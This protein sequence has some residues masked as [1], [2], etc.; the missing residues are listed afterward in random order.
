MF[1]KVVLYCEYCDRHKINIE[2][3][4]T[5]SVAE[6][7]KQQFADVCTQ[8]QNVHKTLNCLFNVCNYSKYY[9]C[10]IMCGSLQYVDQH[11]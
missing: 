6:R 4:I 7:S 1:L 11:C 3:R 5:T 9:Q 2:Y 10:Y 8:A